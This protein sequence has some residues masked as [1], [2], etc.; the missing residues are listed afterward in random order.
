MISQRHRRSPCTPA[1]SCSPACCCC[2]PGPPRPRT[3]IPTGRCSAG[4]SRWCSPS[5]GL[6]V[7]S[8]DPRAVE[9]GVDAALAGENAE[10][11]RLAR[12]LAGE[13]FED[14]P[15]QLRGRMQ[16]FARDAAALARKE[17]ARSAERGDSISAER[18]VQAR[19]ELTAI[20]LRYYDAAQ[21]LDAVKRDDALAVELYVVGRGVNL[22][23]RDA[24]GRSALEIARRARATRRSCGCLRRRA[25]TLPSGRVP[26][27]MRA[28]SA[29]GTSGGQARVVLLEREGGVRFAAAV[30]PHHSLCHRRG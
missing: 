20:G 22:A 29:S 26:E 17:R 1:A 30:A 15:P 6:A 19:K 27:W 28:P 5:C 23:A 13:M 16:A 9:K 7:Q 3:M 18:S 10:V 4:S 2:P 25:R 8:D 14:M 12:E 11:N 21:F 24:D